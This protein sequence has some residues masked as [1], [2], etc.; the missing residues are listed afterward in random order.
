MDFVLALLIWFFVGALFNFLLACILG[1]LTGNSEWTTSLWPI[2]ASCIRMSLIIFLLNK[3]IYPTVNL[4]VALIVVDV[5]WSFCMVWFMS[6]GRNA[7][8]PAGMVKAGNA[9]GSV[10]FMIIFLVDYFL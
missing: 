3:T 5:I 2:A 8:M 10:L 7:L 4:V 9:I 6:S 1:T